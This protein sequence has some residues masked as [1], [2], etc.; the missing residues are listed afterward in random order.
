MSF[1]FHPEAEI[2]FNQA[3]D[4]YEDCRNGL[5]YEFSI[6]VLYAIERA[7]SYPKT[8]FLIQGKIRRSLV[9]RFPYAILY[10]ELKNEVYILAVMNLHKKPGYW[11][12]RK[13]T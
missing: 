6:E 11:K 1:S 9:N 12:K 7:V 5:G 2:E 3:I 8:W 4:Y 13:Y 10:T